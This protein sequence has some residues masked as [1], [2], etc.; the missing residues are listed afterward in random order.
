MKLAAYLRVST[1]RQAEHGLGLDVQR[2]TIKEW[3]KTNGHR[4]VLWAQ[5]AGVSGSNGLDAREGLFDAIS[6]VQE[7]SAEGIVVYKL[8]RLARDFVLQETLLSMV[9]K[10]GGRI[11]SCSSGEDGFLDP[12]NESDDPSRTMVRQILGVIAEYE[13]S[14]IRMRMRAGK[15][16]KRARG[17]YIGG[18]VP[19]GYELGDDGALVESKIEQAALRRMVDL[20]AEGATLR[21]ICDILTA[22]GFETKHGGIWQTATVGQIMKRHAAADS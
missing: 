4:I 5:D 2:A 14:V 20:R 18:R 21:A 22:E 6:A 13:R 10:A 3:A 17:G 19:F 7:E 9:W 16:A 11:Y 1:D 15:L 8:D 12:E